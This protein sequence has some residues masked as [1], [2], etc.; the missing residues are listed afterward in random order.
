MQTKINENKL[1]RHG[2]KWTVNECLELER[3]YDLLKLTIDEIAVK[4]QRTSGAIMSKLDNEG[5]VS[6]NELQ[7]QLQMQLQIS[8][9]KPNNAITTRYNHNT[10]VSETIYNETLHEI[11]SLIDMQKN[12]SSMQSQIDSLLSIVSETYNKTKARFAY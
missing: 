10:N 3:E 6:Y 1:K 9:I 4:H 11:V 7:M 5:I 12:M 2:N 8:E